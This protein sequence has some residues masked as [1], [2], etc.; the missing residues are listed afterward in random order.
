MYPNP[1]IV[2]AAT[3]G[4]QLSKLFKVWCNLCL[5]NA[6]RKSCEPLLEPTLLPVNIRILIRSSGLF[7]SFDMATDDTCCM[8]NLISDVTS[9]TVEDEI[10]FNFGSH[11]R[12]GLARFLIYTLDRSICLFFFLV[13]VKLSLEV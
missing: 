11:E 6:S 13:F 8:F 7:G 2:F 9:A 5:V 10:S 12:T 4:R 3:P 1:L